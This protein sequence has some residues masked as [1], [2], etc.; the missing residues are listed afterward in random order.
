MLGEQSASDLAEKALEIM[1]RNVAH[2]S[3]RMIKALRLTCKR[4]KVAADARVKQFLLSFKEQEHDA[5]QRSGLLN[6]ITKLQIDFNLR[7]SGKKTS[8][9]SQNSSRAVGLLNLAVDAC[10][11]SDIAD[12]CPKLKHLDMHSNEL[13]RPAITLLLGYFGW[14]DRSVASS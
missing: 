6:N 8:I 1:I 12:K 4:T 10:S 13:G 2:T 14:N 5:V 9:D 3:K 7:P 11:K